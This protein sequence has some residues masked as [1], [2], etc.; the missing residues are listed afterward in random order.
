MRRAGT[1][2]VEKNK[3]E[4]SLPAA[5]SENIGMFV[6]FH[7]FDDNPIFEMC[8]MTSEHQR[9]EEDLPSH[10]SCVRELDRIADFLDCDL[11]ECSGGWRNLV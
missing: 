3:S 8:M 4:G 9:V 7:H 5:C 1:P 11:H 2:S 6:P 10:S